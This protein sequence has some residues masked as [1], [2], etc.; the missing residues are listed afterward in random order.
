MYYVTY[1][2][3]KAVDLDCRHILSNTLILYLSITSFLISLQ[4][5]YQQT[6]LIEETKI[7]EK[8]RN[9]TGEGGKSYRTKH[10]LHHQCSEGKVFIMLSEVGISYSETKALGGSL[11]ENLAIY[12]MTIIFNT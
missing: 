9:M 12:M 10:E 2:Y 7:L 3:I 1:P 4:R 6:K 5:I 11:V 8:T